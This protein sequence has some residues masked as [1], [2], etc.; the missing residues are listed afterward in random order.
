MYKKDL[1]WTEEQIKNTNNWQRIQRH[2]LQVNK[3]HLQKGQYK[4][5]SLYKNLQKITK[6]QALMN[7]EQTKSRVDSQLKII[8][9]SLLCTLAPTDNCRL[10]WGSTFNI[11]TTWETIL[12]G[13]NPSL[14]LPLQSEFETRMFSKQK[15]IMIKGVRTTFACDKLLENDTDLIRYLTEEQNKQKRIE[16]EEH[17]PYWL[18]LESDTTTNEQS[19]IKYICTK[20][21][22][23]ATK[24]LNQ[25]L[26]EERQHDKVLQRKRSFK[27]SQNK[28]HL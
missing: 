22:K 16:V 7:W 23:L 12:L 28:K 11:N 25:W 10:L 27:T 20:D 24:I 6:D 14:K 9:I 8:N 15:R 4:Q 17:D 21:K 18:F 2:T 19:K 5:E 13:C 3:Y 1:D 26:D